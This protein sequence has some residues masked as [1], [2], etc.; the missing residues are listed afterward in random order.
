M[1][2]NKI[3]FVSFIILICTVFTLSITIFINGSKQINSIIITNYELSQN[4][5]E[6]TIQ[7]S[8]TDSIGFTRGFKDNNNDQSKH[9]LTFYSCYGLFNSKH[10]AKSEFT[11][12]LNKDDSEIYFN[13]PNKTYE[14][15]LQK[16]KLT[17]QWEFS[18]I[19]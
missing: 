19:K 2:K 10:N 4:G 1:K 9:Y 5:E 15:V 3:A 18:K 6:L 14:L 8:S 11:I 13:R 7:I 12:K 17:G 16:N